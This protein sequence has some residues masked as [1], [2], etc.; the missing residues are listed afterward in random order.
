MEFEIKAG[1]KLDL[2]NRH[3]LADVLRDWQLEAMRGAVPI[4][5]DAYATPAGNALTIDGTNN[6]GRLGPDPGMFWMVPRVAVVGLNNAAEATHL[7]VNSVQPR[8]LILPTL[9]G[10]A[11]STGYHE[12]P[13][14]Q[15]LLTGNDRL[16]LASTGVIATATNVTLVGSAWEL[17]IGLLW[18]L[19]G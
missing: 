10:V 5:F 14:A 12:F 13:G 16:I 19:L 3:E 4:R 11:G 2:L 6:S 1:A 8:N 15:V 7:Y 18:R 9:S 17:P